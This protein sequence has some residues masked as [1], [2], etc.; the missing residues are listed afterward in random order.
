[1]EAE[2]RLRLN[3]LRSDQV[4]FDL[5][6]KYNIGT[7]IQNGNW[8]GAAYN[9]GSLEGGLAVEAAGGR[10]VAEGVNGVPSGPFRLNDSAQNYNP[11]LGSV[12]SWLG[13]GTNV[14]SA[15]LSVGA[16]GSGASGVLGGGK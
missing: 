11:D 16:G 6:A 3:V 8:D 14:G 7:D 5:F 4:K 13:K 1:V 2:I 12:W 10:A 15:G 9:V